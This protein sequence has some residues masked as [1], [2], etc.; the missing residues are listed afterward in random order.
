MPRPFALHP[1]RLL[2]APRLRVVQERDG[3]SEIAIEGLVCGLC[4]RRTE[5]ALSVLPG[6]ERADVDLATGRACLEHRGRPPGER[7]LAAALERVVIA[8]RWRR[9]IEAI[10]RRV[11][12]YAARARALSR[13]GAR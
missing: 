1:W 10:A 3:R 8:P 12:D 6:V 4:A 7:E 11:R 5:R 13:G 9:R 2:T